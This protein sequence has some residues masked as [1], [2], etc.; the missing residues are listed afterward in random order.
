MGRPSLFVI[1]PSNEQY[2]ERKAIYHI[3]KQPKLMKMMYR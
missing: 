2:A 1:I 3:E